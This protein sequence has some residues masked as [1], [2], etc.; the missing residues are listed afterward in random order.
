MLDLGEL[1]CFLMHV[2]PAQDYREMPLLPIDW[3][4]RGC[5][6]VC[7]EADEGV[8][9]QQQPKGYNGSENDWL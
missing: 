4:M 5:C 9:F 3:R 8:H 6:C 1:V 7:A 2:L